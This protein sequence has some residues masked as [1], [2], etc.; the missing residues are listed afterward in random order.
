MRVCEKCGYI[1]PIEWR[2]T[3]WKSA[4]Y[5]DCCRLE[6]LQNLDPELASDLKRAHNTTEAT[7]IKGMYAY[8]LTKPGVWV[9]RRW[10]PIYEIQDWREIPAE[11]HKPKRAR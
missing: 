4:Q 7:I 5:I 8:R 1:E 3:T 9:L 6:D 10:L 11:Q 2:P